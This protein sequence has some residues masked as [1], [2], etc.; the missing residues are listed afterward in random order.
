MNLPKG[1]KLLPFLFTVL[2]YLTANGQSTDEINYKLALEFYQNKE[3]EKS[4]SLFEELYKKDRSERIYIPYFNSLLAI[5]KYNEAENLVKKQLKRNHGDPLYQVDYGYVVKLSGNH[6]KAGGIYEDAIKDLL[7]RAQDVLDLS[8][9][10]Q[11]RNE[12]EFAISTLKYGKK[13]TPTYGYQFE[14]AELYYQIGEI[15]KMVNEY[16]NLLTINDAYLQNVQN[17]LNTAIY[18]DLNQEYIEVLN[19]ALL[20]KIQRDPDRVIFSELLIWHYLQQKDFRG[21]IIQSKALDKRNEESGNRF[22]VL[23]NTCFSNRK[24]DLAMECYQY[25]IDK[26][27]SSRHYINARV[28]MTETIREKIISAPF[29]QD[30][31]EVL[32]RNYIQTL[33]DIGSTGATISLQIGL[34]EVWAFYLHKQDQAVDLLKK[35]LNTYQLTA[36]DEA[37]CKIL[38]A[39][40]YLKESR[41]LGGLFTIFS[42]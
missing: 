7:P 11:R 31:L 32:E 24:Y 21:A 36:K 20:R 39:D 35:A 22:I 5:E 18:Q 19:T 14:L 23:G 33:E 4:I 41:N 30:D 27:P 40:I 42:G 29:S 12:I 17:A 9:S 3:Y 8:N 28:L 34:A 13:L 1:I 10:F 15:D 16:L 2:F 26:G 38:L 25:L 37:Q 6:R